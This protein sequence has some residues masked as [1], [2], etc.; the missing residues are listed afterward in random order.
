MTIIRLHEQ[1]IE[2]LNARGL[3]RGS[4][5]LYVG[6]EACAVGTVAALR[7]EDIVIGYYR[8]H[9][10]ALA[11]GV[12]T[13]SVMSEVLG[14]VTGCCGGRGGTKHLMDVSRNYLG[15]FAIVGQQLPLG[16]GLALAVKRAVATGDR[17]PSLA[18]CFFGDGAANQGVALEA[19]NLATVLEV[20]CLFVCEN[21]EYAVSSPARRMVG[22]GSIAARA[23][24]FGIE[25]AEVDG[26]DVLA[27]QS[28]VARARAHVVAESKPMFLELRTYRYH[29][30]SVFQVED[31]YR[32]PSE[33]AR[34]KAR[35]PIAQLEQRLGQ[36]DVSLAQLDAEREAILATLREDAAWSAD[37]PLLS[38]VTEA[39][40]YAERVSGLASWG[41]AA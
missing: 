10:H 18:A 27:V 12:P 33:I 11:L 39:D 23:A 15:A 8:S 20:P 5:H 40:V 24:G 7:S 21:N 9:G 17:A 1:V 38:D 13:R 2:D 26:M 41:T 22:G 3:I 14:R 25:A 6:M 34:F 31:D 19:L 37:Q 32:E 29:G 30:H 16:V 35:D 36:A 4:T 28:A